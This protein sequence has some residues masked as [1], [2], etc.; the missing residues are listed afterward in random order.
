MA[1]RLASAVS[2]YLRS[3]AD[4]PVDWF[5]WGPEPFEEARRRDVPVLLSIG[6]ATCHWC[7][8]MARESFSDPDLASWLNERFVSIKVDREEHPEVDQTYM[9]A[10]GAFTSSLGWPLTV[11]LTPNGRA[12]YAGTYF[13]PQAVGQL[14]SFRD[15][16]TAV[17]DAWDNRRA[18]LEHDAGRIADAIAAAGRREGSPLPGDAELDAV[19]RELAQYEDQQHRGFGGAPKFPVAPVV[20]FLLDRGDPT[21]TATRMLDAMRDSELR[22]PVEGGFFRYAV[23]R[24]WTEPH[25]ERMLYD[26]AGLLRAY[27]R[28]GD[29]DTASGIAHFLLSVLRQQSGAFA[30][31]QDSESIIDG[32]RNEGGYYR[33]D[34]SERARLA[35]PPLDDKVLTGLNGLGIEA[36][37]DAGQRLRH[38]EWVDAAVAAATAVL[39][40]HRLPDGTLLRASVADRVSEAPATLEDYGGLACGL[41]AVALATGEQSWAEAA[42]DLIDLVL[43]D[44]DFRV[45]GEGDPVLAAA[46]LAL[47][48]D[49]NEGATPSGASL[50]SRAALR[51]FALTAH[52]PYRAAAERAM[53]RLAQLALEQAI[54]F[55]G[56]LAVMSELAAPLRQIVVVGPG[57]GLADRV[58]GLDGPGV[59]VA[60]VTEQQAGAW[61]AAG[62]ELFEGRTAQGGR[63]TAYVCEQ[64]VCRLPVTDAAGLEPL[65]VGIRSAGIGPTGTRSA[66]DS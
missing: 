38:P 37:A 16:L 20:N 23:R 54:S 27:A 9:T 46:G 63:E 15:V 56:A 14:P 53:G 30:S 12:F 59:L 55:G 34:A 42:R 4:N 21:G 44:G 40:R 58:R 31:A 7:H 25:Y 39:R 66:D 19:V 1:N 36:L 64:F 62:F 17:L 43:Q 51:L 35:P 49:P 45:P 18:Q 11:F 41:L 10:A 22:D 2:P 57:G 48:A 47:D 8:V 50:C 24:D 6:Y 52:E 5:A 65:L 28:A 29:E 60:T 32:Q 26:N 61:T 3:H 33:A 13:P